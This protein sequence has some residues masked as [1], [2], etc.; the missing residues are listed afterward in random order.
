[1]IFIP[2][3]GYTGVNLITQI[4][5]SICPWYTGPSLISALDAM[6]P[7]PRLDKSALRIPVLDKYRDRGHTVVIGKVESGTIRKGHELRISPGFG[8][9]SISILENDEQEVNKL[10][11]GENIKI[12][13]K[14]SQ[15]SEDDIQP[16]F[17][18]YRKDRGPHVTQDI[19]ATIVTMKLGTSQ[20]FTNAFSAVMHIHTC[21]AEVS[22]VSLLEQKNLKTGERMKL[23][24]THVG[25][26]SMVVA[27]LRIERPI[28]VERYADFPQLGRFTLRDE[29]RTIAFGMGLSILK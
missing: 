15:I 26:R 1:V 7:I 3:S 28:P 22:V 8:S 24:P 19:V 27:H 6:G 13:L 2:I 21:V 14:S 9:F 12:L 18:I 20:L 25:S 4:D 16:G 5:P 29:G 23:N 17:V 10:K 11:G